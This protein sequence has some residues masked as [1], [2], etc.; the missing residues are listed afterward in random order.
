MS[1]ASSESPSL[2]SAAHHV[3]R[4]LHLIRSYWTP[5]LKGILLGPIVGFLGMATPY[6]SKLLIDEVYPSQDVGLMHVLVGGILGV[7]VASTAIR[8]LQRIYNVHFEVE[9]R[10]KIRL[11]FFNHMQH[12]PTSFFND[13]KVGE[14]TSRFKDASGALITLTTLFRTSI[15]Q[16]IYLL[17]VPPFL[18][19][20]HWKLAIVAVI[21]IPATVAVVTIAG[22]RWREA[23]QDASEAYADLYAH[24]VETLS[25]IRMVKSLSVEHTMFERARDHMTRATETHRR[26]SNIGEAVQAANDGLRS[27]N[28][29]LF[30][31]LGW[32][33]I[34]DGSLTLG[35][36]IAF[37]AYV[38]FLYDPLKQLVDLYAKLQ[39]SSVNLWRMFEYLDI[40]PEQD[41]TRVYENV[42]TPIKRRL[43]GKV[44]LRDLSFGYDDE[45]ILEEVNL[46]VEP[47][48]SVAVVGPSGSG[49]T[50]LLRLLSGLEQPTCGD[51]LLDDTEMDAL[52]LA[53]VRRQVMP[54]W[55]ELTLFEG[56]IRSNL[57]LGLDD[58]TDAE[59][60]RVTKLCQVYD[61]IQNTENGYDTAVAEWGASLSGGQRQRLVLARALLRKAPVYLLDEV[62]SNLDM[63]TEAAL[64]PAMFEALQ[65][66][67]VLFVT[68]RVESARYA[69][70]I[71]V[72]EDGRV[73]GYGTHDQLL[74]TCSRYAGLCD[75]TP[76]PMAA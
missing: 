70:R 59:L 45:A 43:Y 10:N 57:T 34:L 39:Q 61:V 76:L 20:L 1:I 13:H 16:G 71:C 17:L 25:Q 23:W 12:L 69:D 41:P 15:T 21:A 24:N 47:G 42:P 53:D 68:H 33:F 54:V 11:L 18:F 7:T 8:Y 74:S 72:I 65:D 48:E 27:F 37:T 51:I 36:Y 3:W 19:Y 28:M 55:Q 9:L 32:T 35:S 63:E 46:V 2:S 52:P 22:N 5:L 38:G 4:L 6:L 58:V 50:T 60:D 67:T 64:L 44:E 40:E 75:A 31:W 14:I 66:E 56:T 73:V 29:A 30:T 62:T 26:S 49:K